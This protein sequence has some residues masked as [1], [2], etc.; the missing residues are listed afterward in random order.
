MPTSRQTWRAAFPF[1]EWTHRAITA[2]IFR[3]GSFRAE[4]MDCDVT[5]NSRRHSASRQRKRFAR[6]PFRVRWYASSTPQNGQT[7]SASPHRAR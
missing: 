4:K 7:G 1:T 6:P 3:S 2:S 5:V